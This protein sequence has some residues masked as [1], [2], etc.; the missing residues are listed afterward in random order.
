[1]HVTQIQ[2]LLHHRRSLMPSLP[3]VWHTLD[4]NSPVL[5]LY[6]M[7]SCLRIYEVQERQQHGRMKLSFIPWSAH[8]GAVV[9]AY[10]ETGVEDWFVGGTVLGSSLSFYLH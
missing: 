5:S 1:M 8:M 7:N 10:P 2:L 4:E 9:T 3:S 6:R